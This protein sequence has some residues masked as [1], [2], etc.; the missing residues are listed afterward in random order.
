MSEETA[1]KLVKFIMSSPSKTIIVEFSGGE[2][3]LNFEGIKY[4]VRESKKVAKEKGKEVIFAMI[5]NGTNWDKKKMKFFIE[6]KIGICFSL[7]G[8]E[9]LHNKQRPYRGGGGSH[10]KVVEWIKKFRK[11]GYPSLNAIPVVTKVTLQ[12]G[13]ELVDEYLSLGFRRI[14]F[15]YLTYFGRAADSWDELGYTPDEFLK[16]WK[17]V[18]EYIFELNKRGIFV[19]EGVTQILAKKIFQSKDPG[20]CELQMPCGAGI[21]QL[22]Y[23]PDG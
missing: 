1:K 23:S 2:P 18:I 19:I 7:D 16:A 10:K 22:A 4:L 13:R 11:V 8:P 9:D 14:R 3:L 17:E 20:F 15:K 21:G 5:H 6:E 12:R